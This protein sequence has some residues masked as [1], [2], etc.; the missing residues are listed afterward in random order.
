MGSVP[1]LFHKKGSTRESNSL[2]AEP[3]DDSFKMLNQCAWGKVLSEWAGICRSDPKA[4]PMEESAKV[5]YTKRSGGL[6]SPMASDQSGQREE[7]LGDK[8]KWLDLNA[9]G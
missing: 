9:A 3:A 7:D 1:E 5:S 2:D 8:T 4:L 6:E